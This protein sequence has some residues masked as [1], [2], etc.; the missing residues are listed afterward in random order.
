M[1]KSA[2]QRQP[3]AD[4][5]FRP[6]LEC[7]QTFRRIQRRSH[8]VLGI[9]LAAL[10]EQQRHQPGVSQ[11]AHRA[12][13]RRFVEEVEAE[14]LQLDDCGVDLLPCFWNGQ[15]Q[16]AQNVGAVEEHI[17]VLR[18]R[19]RKGP[20]PVLVQDQR[21][22]PEPPNDFFEIFEL[23]EVDD[24]VAN[25]EL[26]RQIRIQRHRHVGR[27]SCGHG[28]EDGVEAADVHLFGRHHAHVDL[29]AGAGREIVVDHIAQNQRP[30]KA[31]S[32]PDRQQHLITRRGVDTADRVVVLAEGDQ[33]LRD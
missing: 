28:Q 21:A 30:L 23:A 32:H 11:A 25:G 17:E 8:P 5:E 12:R 14:L 15:A 22:R 19:Q 27:L 26:D 29:D 33:K 20:F 1:K 3:V 6:G 31:A 10:L 7:G 2:W 4:E 18:F 24:S 9:P 16:L 13:R